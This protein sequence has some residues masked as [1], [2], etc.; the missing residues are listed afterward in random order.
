[1]VAIKA[2][3]YLI[4]EDKKSL[5]IKTVP[6]EIRVL[7]VDGKRMTLSV[8]RQ[9]IDGDGK[10]FSYE[11]DSFLINCNVLGWVK[12]PEKRSGVN[13][14]EKVL[15]YSRAG[16]LY[17]NMASKIERFG[18]HNLPNTQG[19]PHEVI[20]RIRDVISLHRDFCG[21]RYVN[22]LKEGWDED[23][24]ENSIFTLDEF[25]LRSYH[26]NIEKISYEYMKSKLFF[27]AE[28]DLYKSYLSIYLECKNSFEIHKQM[29][30]QLFGDENQIFISI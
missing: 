27:M 15:V 22:I 7:L 4:M 28:L 25:I 1:M 10:L 6:V 2:H 29:V 26:N 24:N 19:S 17:K 16:V 23:L 20:D 5:S 14:S 8:F 11:N 21:E 13:W 18:W 30:Y 3:F 9:I 12:N